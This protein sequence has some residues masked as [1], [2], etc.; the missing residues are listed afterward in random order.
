MSENGAFDLAEGSLANEEKALPNLF[1][2]EERL[3]IQWKDRLLTGGA[4][5]VFLFYLSG[6]LVLSYLVFCPSAPVI[7]WT[8]G[9]L[10]GLMFSVPSL[11]AIQLFK[12]VD[13]QNNRFTAK[14]LEDHPGIKLLL[15]IAR[16]IA[17]AW[18]K[19]P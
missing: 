4:I 8:H 14:D 5:V 9:L 2:R 13:R 18:K 19:T 16:E 7:N 3:R 12:L 17:I 1:L 6:L 10:L 15:E 11:M